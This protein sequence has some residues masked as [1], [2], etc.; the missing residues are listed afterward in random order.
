MG[1]RSWVNVVLF[2]FLVVLA[3]VERF[4]GDTAD[5]TFHLVLATLIVL[6][7]WERRR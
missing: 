5:A 7:G 2:L 1:V 6:V 3:G 4:F